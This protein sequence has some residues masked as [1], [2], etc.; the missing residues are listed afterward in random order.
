[1]PIQRKGQK[2]AVGGGR[3]RQ[4]WTAERKAI[5]RQIARVRDA[6][7]SGR[8][9]RLA[10][11]RTALD[12]CA[13]QRDEDD[14]WARVSQ[15]DAA[16]LLAFA[17]AT[18]RRVEW[19]LTGQGA[20]LAGE[21]VPRG[22]LADNVRDMC[23]NALPPDDAAWLV[24]SG[25]TIDGAAC[26]EAITTQTAAAVAAARRHDTVVSALRNAENA[27]VRTSRG[28]AKADR[29]AEV[30]FAEAW[31]DALAVLDGLAPNHAAL[32]R[33]SL[34]SAAEAMRG[35]ADAAVRK[36]RYDAKRA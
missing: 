14:A 4:E 30:A 8:Q 25:S 19:L 23:L 28:G 9:L 2:R 18:G 10:A 15:P 13:P 16:N 1:M 7:G 31:R 29:V 32:V 26:L 27:R 24:A 33:S 6:Y 22:E 36:A 5:A 20:E 12:W 34:G 35:R 17:R 3:P 21:T 11:G